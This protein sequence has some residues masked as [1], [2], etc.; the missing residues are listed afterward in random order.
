MSYEQR[1]IADAEGPGPTPSWPARYPA[2]P[3]AGPPGYGRQSPAGPPPWAYPPPGTGARRPRTLWYA[4]GAALVVVGVI[5][6]I[7]VFFVTL[8][9]V[10]GQAP[11]ND[12]TFGNGE[13]TT[14]HIDAG[15]SKTIYVTTDTS[16]AQRI[17][18]VAQDRGQHRQLSPYH[19]EVTV[20][21]WRAVSTLTAPA[22]G[23]YTISCSGPPDARY[24]IGGHISSGNFAGPFA[25]AG[26]GVAVF[27][28]GI[29]T[30]IVTAIHRNRRI[31]VQPALN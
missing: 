21:Q 3:S 5:G 20:N 17:A 12:H 31:T 1:P 6:G 9:Q 10:T 30:L 25:A 16:E 18:C 27:I 22:G 8:L 7:S 24:G 4:V 28:A 26:T 2:A 19:A 15:T 11:T 29:V 23:D 13:T 14:V